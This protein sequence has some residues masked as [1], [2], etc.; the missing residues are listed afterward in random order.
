MTAAH[1]SDGWSWRKGDHPTAVYRL[2]DK[3]GHLLYVGITANTR[4]RW[5]QHASYKQWWHLVDR[6][7][8][9]WYDDREDALQAEYGVMLAESPIFNRAGVS[10]EAAEGYD[11]DA[12]AVE[13]QFI[14]ELTSAL[15]RGVYQEGSLLM[16]GKVA[17]QYGVARAT[18]SHAMRG[19]ARETDLLHFRIHGRYTVTARAT[20]AA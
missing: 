1:V 19:I 3:S 9:D 14:E 10:E 13:R 20:R 18:A 15:K 6:K 4:S 7:V 17:N 8:V 5:G 2:Y 11:F 16:T 12:D